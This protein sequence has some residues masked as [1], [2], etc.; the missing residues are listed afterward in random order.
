GARRGGRGEGAGAPARPR[1]RAP[2]ALQDP[3]SGSESRVL[4]AG[5]RGS[6]AA[7]S[8][9]LLAVWRIDFSV[10]QVHFPSVKKTRTKRNEADLTVRLIAFRS[11]ERRVGKE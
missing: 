8:L 1:L 5:S 7:E 6:A 10:G 9:G 2:A 4:L 3:A 11:E